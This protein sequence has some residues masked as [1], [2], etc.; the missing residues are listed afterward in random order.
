MIFAGLEGRIQSRLDHGRPVDRDQP[1]ARAG[2]KCRG[3]QLRISDKKGCQIHQP[4]ADLN[5]KCLQRS[6]MGHSSSATARRACCRCLRRRSG[7]RRRGCRCRRHERNHGVV[8]TCVALLNQGEQ[9][10]QHCR[11]LGQDGDVVLGVCDSIEMR[12]CVQ[13]SQHPN[14]LCLVE[15]DRLQ[16]FG[17]SHLAC[18]APGNAHGALPRPAATSLS[19][20]PG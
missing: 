11:R 1:L 6:S 8:V 15:G 12:V 17:T 18:R 20:W 9:V 14:L 13:K 5:L 19:A 16:F 7:S 10:S 2:Q 4:A 3:I